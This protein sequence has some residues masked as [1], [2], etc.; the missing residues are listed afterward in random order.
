MDV[1]P[2][3]LK[4]VSSDNPETLWKEFE[5]TGSIQAYMRYCRSV[6]MIENLVSSTLPS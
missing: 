1:Q 3:N 2:T 6:E 5:K 4:V